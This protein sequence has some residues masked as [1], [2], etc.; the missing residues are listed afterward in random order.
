M[1]TDY[2]RLPW[3][4]QPSDYSC[5]PMPPGVAIGPGPNTLALGVLNVKST[6][7]GEP[8]PHPLLSLPHGELALFIAF[9]NIGR[10]RGRDRSTSLG[11]CP[12]RHEKGA[13]TKCGIS[14]FT[15]V[16]FLGR[17]Q[18]HTERVVLLP[19]GFFG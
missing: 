15:I 11:L 19:K 12:D 3:Y 8:N 16:F 7:A 18:P 10:T 9:I 17:K 13:E 2:G 1:Y 5:S 14:G 4:L 6:A